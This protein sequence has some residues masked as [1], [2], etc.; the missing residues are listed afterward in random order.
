MRTDPVLVQYRFPRPLANAFV[1]MRRSTEDATRLGHQLAFEHE[2]VRFVALAALADYLADDERNDSVEALLS[3]MRQPGPV[4]WVE[5]LVTLRDALAVRSTPP[6]VPELIAWLAEEKPGDETAAPRA[7]PP[8]PPPEATRRVDR[9]DGDGDGADGLDDETIDVA[10]TMEDIELVALAPESVREHLRQMAETCRALCGADEPW[11]DDEAA[12]RLE[13]RR[14]GHE[15]L[16]DSVGFLADYVVCSIAAPALAETP[17]DRVLRWRGPAIEMGLVHGDRGWRPARRR[18]YLLRTG[19][20]EALSLYPLVQI[21]GTEDAAGALGLL[22]TFSGRR[23]RYGALTYHQ[24]YSVPVFGEADD[25]VDVDVSGAWADRAA[26]FRREAVPEDALGVWCPTTPEIA[27]AAAPRPSLEL[28]SPLACGPDGVVY[29]GRDRETGQDVAVRVVNPMALARDDTLPELLHRVQARLQVQHP[30]LVQFLG[31]EASAAGGSLLLLSEAMDGGSLAD[32]LL[33]APLPPRQALDIAIDVLGALSTLHDFGY[34]HNAIRAAGVQFTADGFTRLADVEVPP[35]LR[36]GRPDLPLAPEAVLGDEQG[37][38]TDQYQAAHLLYQML[39]GVAPDTHAPIPPSHTI[40]HPPAVVDGPV[41][42]ALAVDPAERPPQ[43]SDFR[44]ALEAARDAL[45]PPRHL[46]PPLVLS[47]LRY[48]NPLCWADRL[49]RLRDAESWRPLLTVH[50]ERARVEADPTARLQALTAAAAVAEEGLG[51]PELAASLWE[52]VFVLQPGDPRSSQNLERLLPKLGRTRRLLTLLEGAVRGEPTQREWRIDLDRRL[53][54]LHRSIEGH[55]EQ[56]AAHWRAVLERQPGDQEALSGLV[57]LSR[58]AG[59]LSDAT[60]LLPELLETARDEEEWLTVAETLA[61]LWSTD[62]YE[63]AAAI[64]LWREIL[65]R[66]PNHRKALFH[67]AKTHR[68][69]GDWRSYAAVL[70]RRIE[71]ETDLGVR[72]NWRREL[73]GVY[74]SHIGDAQGAIDT[75]KAGLAEVTGET[76]AAFRDELERLYRK[77]A[78]WRTLVDLLLTGYETEP[79][80]ER[81]NRLLIRLAAVFRDRLNAPDDALTTLQRAVIDDPTAPQARF[82][83][84]RAAEET[85]AWDAFCDVIEEV[86][87]QMPAAVAAEYGARATRAAW[88]RLEDAERT[89]RLALLTLDRNPADRLT[90]NLLIDAS[91]ALERWED[92]V[93]ALEIVKDLEGGPHAEARFH[94][95]LARIFEQHIGDTEQAIARADDARRADPSDAEPLLVLVRLFGAAERWEEQAQALRDL[96]GRHPRGEGHRLAALARLLKQ[97]LGRDEEAIATA[98]AALVLDLSESERRDALLLLAELY[99]AIKEWEPLADVLGWLA[100]TPQSE[101]ERADLLEELAAIEEERLD[102]PLGAIARY[103]QVVELSPDRTHA[104]ESLL[105]LTSERADDESRAAALVAAARATTDP[106][107]RRAR[108]FELADLLHDRLGRPRDGLDVL[109]HILAARPDDEEVLV[110]QARWHRNLQDGH[111][112]ERAVDCL[113][114]VAADALERARWRTRLVEIRA[115]RGESDETL[116]PLLREAIAEAPQC[117]EAHAALVDRIAAGDGGDALVAALE[118]WAAATADAERRADAFVRLA[119]ARVSRGERGAALAALDAALHAVPEHGPASGR[120]LKL[121]IEDERWDRCLPLVDLELRRT[122]AGAPASQR[123]GLHGLAGDIAL[124]LGEPARAVSSYER[125]LALTPRDREARCGLARA[126]RKAD[127]LEDARRAWSEVLET[128]RDELPTDVF[129]EAHRALEEINRTLGERGRS[130]DHLERLLADKPDDVETLRAILPICEERGDWERVVEVRQKLVDR[131]KDALARFNHLLAIGEAR[132][133]HLAAPEGAIAA[134]KAALVLQPESQ[135]AR[136]GL[137]DAQVAGGALEEAVETLEALIRAADS[138]SR[139]AALHH[140]L[141]VVHRD[142]R[143]DDEEAIR[144]FNAALDLDPTRLQSFADLDAL[145]VRRGD[146]ASQARSYKK[147][148]LRLSSRKA[149]GDRTIEHRL[150]YNLGQLY[151]LHLERHDDAVVALE[152]AIDRAP[153]ALPPRR[154]LARLLDERPDARERAVSQHRAILRLSAREVDTYRALRRHFAELGRFDAAWCAAGVLDFL[155]SADDR[156]KAFYDRFRTGSLHVSGPPLD[157]GEWRGL[158]ILGTEDPT[159]GELFALLLQ[160]LGG[161]LQGA[162]PKDHGLTPRDLVDVDGRQGPFSDLYAAVVRLLG[163]KPP[164]VYRRLPGSGIRTAGTD[165]AVLLVAEDL[166]TSHQGKHVRFELGK[167]LAF[168]HPW[169]LLTANLQVPTLRR[170][171]EVAARFT[172]PEASD[173]SADEDS[174]RLLRHLRRKLSPSDVQHLNELGHRVKSRGDVDETLE[175]WLHAVERTTN[176]VGLL[177]ANDIEVAVQCVRNETWSA[178]HMPLEEQVD[179]LLR[180]AVSDEYVRLRKRVGIQIR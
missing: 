150:W 29:R 107:E 143:G 55:A 124:N 27:P 134:Y 111:G 82:A 175:R 32:L 12:R 46:D 117:D 92:L 13:A 167:A 136:I 17:V 157:V 49:A 125:A 91:T 112:E 57:D 113:A 133:H 109:E 51:D 100:E 88:F 164:S 102:R 83:F 168:Q 105:R 156:E 138:P 96:E 6:F 104:R 56:A 140:T 42:R 53:A 7:V 130:I 21:V 28:I 176:H 154:L 61:F 38:A 94:L 14:P 162:R 47:F 54:R 52:H 58:R 161:E 159:V 90:L 23:P 34:V 33:E 145:L 171:L 115:A 37:A 172:L 148:L 110:R 114:R 22:S 63:E 177:L 98:R 131:S 108:R 70:S 129:A 178:E 126:L 127:R 60:S 144:H 4:E 26:W 76:A 69:R 151:A 72:A 97:G 89:R 146:P 62:R 50:R 18:P 103:R 5:L 173:G 74:G 9:A 99:R 59:A 2:L 68:L 10:R 15:R 20:A 30:S 179:D 86:L 106:D 43:A 31:W 160:H 149:G 25:D 64:A 44:A 77:G 78:R 169:H 95:Q 152:E 11:D 48:L 118:H 24:H 147:M 128:A 141:A 163:T 41:L 16:L 87:S 66:R 135:A 153:E 180:Y 101:D 139:R 93:R 8:P 67:L 174:R 79:P 75:L 165:P 142:R 65:D 45:P 84:W 39:T 19:R 166:L 121:S 1:R 123:A 85:G 137:L 35:R 81:R 158:I 170:L 80:G 71:L 36:A 155:E 116:L 122:P 119:D 73:A 132:M 120:L 40:A 3:T